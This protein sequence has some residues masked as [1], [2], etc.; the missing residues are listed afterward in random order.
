MCI[1]RPATT[2]ALNDEISERLQGTAL[3]GSYTEPSNGCGVAQA[4]MTKAVLLAPRATSTAAAAILNMS[5][6]MQPASAL[7]LATAGRRL[8]GPGAAPSLMRRTYATQHSL[9][10]TGA[11]SSGPRRKSVTPFNDDGHVPWSELSAG[12][13]AA[14]ATQQTFNFG[15]ILVGIVLT[16]RGSPY[17]ALERRRRLIV[18]Y[19]WA[20]G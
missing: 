7:S 15:L 19:L 1:T 2:T 8:S 4:T 5:T 18:G 16:V 17:P 10:A 12:E 9:G 6:P 20:H 3:R 11:A 13:K 14:R